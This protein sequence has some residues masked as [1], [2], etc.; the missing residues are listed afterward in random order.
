MK[1][2]PKQYAAALYDLLDQ[3]PGDASP[4]IVRRFIML[5]SRN[6]DLSLWRRIVEAFERLYYVRQGKTRA[7]VST[8]QTSKAD[9]VRSV[10]GKTSDTA[11]RTDPHLI[12]GVAIRIGDKLIDNSVQSRM[13]RLREALNR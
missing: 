11:V 6:R 12:G 8:A 7:I 2:T 13:E 5:L 4:D 1:Y 10:L 9:Y 3:H